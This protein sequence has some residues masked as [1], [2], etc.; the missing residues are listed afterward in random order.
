MSFA[1]DVQKRSLPAEKTRNS[2][3]IPAVVY[4]P[5]LASTSV[6][7]DY[8]V[9]D[10]LYKEAGE[11]S[12]IDLNVAGGQPTKVLIQEVQRDPVSDRIIHV[13]FRQIN[14]NKEMHATIS[15]SF[16]GESVAVKEL[17]GT[18]VKTLDELNIKC[19]PKDLVSHVTVNLSVLK[20]FDDAI[21]ISDIAL[22]AGITVTDNLETLV[23]KVA[24]PLT[25]EELKA[26]EEA[27]AASI[28][29]IE[30]E[31]KGKKEEEGAEAEAGAEKKAE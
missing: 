14:M 5:Q 6:V 29:D 20:T 19:L 22:P 11:S 2:G 27:P 12:L 16:E 1:L 10:R 24:P 17:G 13:D 30:V 8:L 7:I 28:E 18:L 23:A 15:I 21:H 25:E 31:E 9:F 3:L 26:M 4:G